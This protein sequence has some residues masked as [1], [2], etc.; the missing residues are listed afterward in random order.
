MAATVYYKIDG[1]NIYYTN[2][3]KSGYTEWSN[4]SNVASGKNVI[5]EL[6][7]GS[8]AI[9]SFSEDMFSGMT[10]TSI[11]Q[12]EY[13]DFSE[14]EVAIDMFAS[15]PN[16]TTANSYNWRMPYMRDIE[17]FF[18]D[19]PKLTTVYCQNW[20]CEKVNY[21]WSMFSGCKS[22][23]RVDFTGWHPT[24]LRGFNYVFHN[25][26]SLLSVNFDDN[27]WGVSGGSYSAA[28]YHT[29]HNCS[30]LTSFS[31]NFLNNTSSIST[32]SY[33]FYGCNNLK[34]LDIG[35]LIDQNINSLEYTFYR[36][37]S[38]KD[39]DLSGTKWTFNSTD[40]LKYTFYSCSSLTK[41]DLSGWKI[42]GAGLNFTGMFDGCSALTEIKVRYGSDWKQNAG[43]TYES[44]SM[45]QGCSKLPN[46]DSVVTYERANDKELYG[47]FTGVWIPEEVT[48]YI[49][50]ENDLWIEASES[51]IKTTS[52]WKLSR[53]WS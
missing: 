39:L 15:C 31:F 6:Y 41:L 19:C 49:K 13:F 35:K 27:S 29:F 44:S 23:T 1:N 22:L 40:A 11:P 45:F 50:N 46:W 33:A 10:N 42:T 28:F 36:C 12:A 53:I 32:L 14:T 20:G 16:L 4:Q 26:N 43:G 21:I 7:N 25:C 38:L 48:A 34:S 30:M 24:Q 3:N 51:Y 8:F 47:Y 18:Y 2:E 52:G 37:Y 9:P 5:V 17:R